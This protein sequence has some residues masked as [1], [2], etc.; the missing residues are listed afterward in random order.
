MKTR[1]KLIVKNKNIKKRYVGS[2]LVWGG[3]Y[4]L[5]HTEKNGGAVL[6]DP[7]SLY[8]A[9][10]NQNIKAENIKGIQIKDKEIYKLNSIPENTVGVTRIEAE[11]ALLEYLELTIYDNTK[12]YEM[13]FYGK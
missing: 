12:Y 5:L 13:K 4:R 6:F 11:P 7:T 8:L 9:Y 10:N 3:G 2:R 1:K